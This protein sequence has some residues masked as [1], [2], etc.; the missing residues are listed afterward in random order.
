MAF[1]SEQFG[2]SG[3]ARNFAEEGIG[4]HDGD[5]SLYYSHR[6]SDRCPG[7]HRDGLGGLPE[8]EAKVESPSPARPQK[9]FGWA[10][11]LLPMP[12]SPQGGVLAQGHFPSGHEQIQLMLKIEQSRNFYW[13]LREDKILFL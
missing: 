1:Y 4:L 9:L 2:A 12:L 3:A 13:C 11:M 5:E 8:S 10:F 7:I 6:L